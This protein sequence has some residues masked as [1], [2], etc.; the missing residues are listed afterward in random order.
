MVYAAL[1]KSRQFSSDEIRFILIFVSRIIFVSLHCHSPKLPI[2]LALLVSVRLMR[3]LLL[4][5][6]PMTQE[7]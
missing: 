1:A 3:A 2:E 4:K 6:A 7:A 5:R